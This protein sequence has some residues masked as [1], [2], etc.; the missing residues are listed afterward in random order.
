MEVCAK[1]NKKMIREFEL[2]DD[3]KLNQILSYPDIIDSG[4]TNPRVTG[5]DY[6]NNKNIVN[7][8]KKACSI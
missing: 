8:I 7:S 3:K 1:K 2:C 5:I 6:D 4:K